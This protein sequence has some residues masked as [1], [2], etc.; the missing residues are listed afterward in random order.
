MVEEALAKLKGSVLDAFDQFVDDNSSISLNISPRSP[1][2]ARS[3]RLAL[4]LASK[5]C[6]IPFQLT[7][8]TSQQLVE[9]SAVA[10]NTVSCKQTIRCSCRYR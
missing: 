8:F 2:L 4:G 3:K 7:S 1:S 10:L 5:A 9:T 6:C